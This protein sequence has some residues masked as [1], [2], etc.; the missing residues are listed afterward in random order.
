MSNSCNY[1]ILD[2]RTGEI[3]RVNLL[4]LE[5]GLEQGYFSTNFGEAATEEKPK[6]KGRANAN[7]K[8]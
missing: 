7:N 6:A 3:V 2:T 4:D 8:A 5:I 1:E